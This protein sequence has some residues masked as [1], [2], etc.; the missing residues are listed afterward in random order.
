L[1][2]DE[3]VQGHHVVAFGQKKLRRRRTYESGGAGDEDS[4]VRLLAS[5]ADAISARLRGQE[6]LRR[7]TTGGM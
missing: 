5:A 2:R 4:H 1:T 3:T 7:L 6:T